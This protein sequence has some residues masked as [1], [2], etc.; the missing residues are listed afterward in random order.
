[1]KTNKTPLYIIL[2]LAL[3]SAVITVFVMPVAKTFG[4]APLGV[5]SQIA[6]SSTISVGP[7]VA[8]TIFTNTYSCTSRV[9]STVSQPI[10][11][12]FSSD[13]TPTGVTGHLQA[14]STTIA[15]DSGIYGCGQVSVYGYG[16]STTITKSEFR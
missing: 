1:M 3:I 4:A 2:A 7:Q 9:I 8:T 12:S 13:I 15:Y 11:I 10:M 14:A 5:V 6:T 16:A